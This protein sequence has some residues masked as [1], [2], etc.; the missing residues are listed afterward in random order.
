MMNNNMVKRLGNVMGKMK[1]TAPYHALDSILTYLMG[2][3]SG[4][5]D[6]AQVIHIASCFNV[7]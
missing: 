2:V 6:M 3:V 1:L 7:S 4:M 5:E